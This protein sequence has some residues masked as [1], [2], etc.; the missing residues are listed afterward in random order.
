MHLVSNEFDGVPFEIFKNQLL[1][2]KKTSSKAYRYTDAVKQFA[3]TLHFYS[4]KAYQY[5][6]FVINIYIY[7]L[8]IL[9]LINILYIYY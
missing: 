8:L 3:L 1:N 6:R 7:I 5:C 2:C 9:K 4:P